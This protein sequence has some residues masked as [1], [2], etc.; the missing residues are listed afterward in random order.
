MEKQI[1]D[2]CPRPNFYEGI[3]RLFDFGGTIDE[4]FY[5]VSENDADYKALVSDWVAVGGDIEKALD[6]FKTDY[7]D[8]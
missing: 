8:K 3:A 2:F 5:Y 4:Y 1:L 7:I 6:I